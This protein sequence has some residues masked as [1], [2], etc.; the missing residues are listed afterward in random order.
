MPYTL[1][2][3]FPIRQ[4]LAV[5]FSTLEGEVQALRKDII[6]MIAYS[7]ADLD[8]VY[9]PFTDPPTCINGERNAS[10]LH[11]PGIRG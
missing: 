10:S 2:P 3:I 7:T 5:A 9:T 4:Q 1:I 6:G 11:A 8:A